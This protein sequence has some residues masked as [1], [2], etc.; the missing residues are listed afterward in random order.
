MRKCNKDFNFQFFQEISGTTE[1]NPE[2]STLHRA[3]KN[4]TFS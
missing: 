1:N 2:K 3:Y 4:A